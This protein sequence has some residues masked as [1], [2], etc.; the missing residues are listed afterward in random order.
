[1]RRAGR[2]G[3]WLGQGGLGGERALGRRVGVALDVVAEQGTTETSAATVTM[4]DFVATAGLR[5][6]VDV[7]RWSFGAGPAFSVGLAALGATP[8]A[9]DARGAT[10]DVVWAGPL[11]ELGVRRTLGR[12]GYVLAE[13]GA[14]DSRRAG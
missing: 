8:R 9:A 11:A 13:A 14:P 6:G 3:L 12:A 10:L 5:F 7:G 1:M 2:P 4:R